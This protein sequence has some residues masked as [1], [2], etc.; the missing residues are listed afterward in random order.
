MPILRG[1]GYRRTRRDYAETFA[2]P[3]GRRVLRDLYLFC[4]QATPTAD[5]HEAVFAQGMQRVFRRIQA[6]TRL[7]ADAVL[8]LADSDPHDP[9]EETD[10]G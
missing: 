7:D 4:M 2:T 3:A 10:H 8:G 9:F 6:M 1:A 5:P